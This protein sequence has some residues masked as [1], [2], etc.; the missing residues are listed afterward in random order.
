MGHKTYTRAFQGFLCSGE[1]LRKLKDWLDDVLKASDDDGDW[2]SFCLNELDNSAVDDEF[3]EL[4]F[5]ITTD[6]CADMRIFVAA[7]PVLYVEEETGVVVVPPCT[8]TAKASAA[9]FIAHLRF[10]GCAVQTLVVTNTN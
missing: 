10:Q 4:I 7:C 5:T 9:K 8:D 1:N 3:P 6:M 2:E